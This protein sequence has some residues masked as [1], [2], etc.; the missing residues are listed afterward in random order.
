MEKKI[1]PCNFKVMLKKNLKIEILNFFRT[2]MKKRS[3]NIC[4]DFQF[5]SRKITYDLPLSKY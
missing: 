2:L 1:L 3:C 4:Y 5:R